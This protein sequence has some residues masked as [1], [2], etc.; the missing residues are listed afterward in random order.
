MFPTILPTKL[1]RCHNPISNSNPN[2][3]NYSLFLPFEGKDK[4]NLSNFE[5]YFL[6]E[7]KKPDRERRNHWK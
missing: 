1:M 5:L 6:S 3:S 7:L 4:L 2:L